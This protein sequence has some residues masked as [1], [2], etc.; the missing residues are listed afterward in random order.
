MKKNNKNQPGNPN[1]STAGD[2]YVNYN[3]RAT[4]KTEQCTHKVDRDEE[5]NELN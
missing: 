5:N 3:D 4:Q 1:S 2:L